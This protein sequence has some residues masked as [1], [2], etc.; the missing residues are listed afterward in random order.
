MKRIHLIVMHKKHL[1]ILFYML[2]I[3]TTAIAID[4]KYNQADKLTTSRNN[5]IGVDAS[6]SGRVAIVIDDFGFNGGGTEEILALNIPITCAVLPFSE[7]TKADSERIRQ[8]GHE[9]IIH[10]PMEPHHGDPRWL[11]EK[12]IKVSLSSEKIEEIIREAIEENPYAVG[13][14]NHMGSK[15]TEDRRVMETIMKVLKEKNM[16]IL[17]SK[18]TMSS[19]IEDVA[20]SY[21]VPYTERSIFLD[22]AKDKAY[23]KKQIKKLGELAVVDGHA[24]AIGHVG[25][26]GGAVTAEAIK[27]MIPE[28]EAMGVEFVYL[29]ELVKEH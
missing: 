20:M 17:D 9:V 26:E 12:G 11:G 15:A 22:N 24:V 7:Y 25:P 27:E 1:R 4:Y 29:S 14:N 21:K 19:I 28:L 2:L 18:T 23:I 5:L 8:Q 16:Y 3:L 10:L 13:A 6:K